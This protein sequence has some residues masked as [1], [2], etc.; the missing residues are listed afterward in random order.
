MGKLW[1]GCCEVP[2]N[3]WKHTAARVATRIV[4][5]PVAIYLGTRSR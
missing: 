4:L 3:V 2:E 5:E 1:S